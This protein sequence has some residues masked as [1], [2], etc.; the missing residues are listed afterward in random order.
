MSGDPRVSVRFAPRE[1]ADLQRAAAEREMTLSAYLRMVLAERAQLEAVSE[2]YRIELLGEIRAAI[3]AAEK[4]QSD[5]LGLIAQLLTRLLPG[6]G[7]GGV[8]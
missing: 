5:A 6:A 4:R 1:F 7:A 8:R 2:R 3:D